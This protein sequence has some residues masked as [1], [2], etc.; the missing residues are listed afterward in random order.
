M[1][2]ASAV[3]PAVQKL[4]DDKYPHMRQALHDLK[5]A[6]DSLQDCGT[7]IF[8]GHREKAMVHVDQAIQECEDGLAE[9]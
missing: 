3:A 1:P 7:E 9:G 6:K 4:D 2:P 5:V 8:H